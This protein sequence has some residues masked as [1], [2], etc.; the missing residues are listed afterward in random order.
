[1]SLYA[2]SLSSDSFFLLLSFIR[3]GFSGVSLSEYGHRQ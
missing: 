3:L 1:M 2:F